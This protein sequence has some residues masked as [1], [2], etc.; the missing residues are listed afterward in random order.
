MTV[1]T[2]WSQ[3]LAFWQGSQEQEQKELKSGL[4]HWF[5]LPLGINLLIDGLLVLGYSRHITPPAA[6]GGE[7]PLHPFTLKHFWD[8]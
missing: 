7:L 4:Y 5:E 2:L 1:P 3:L 6:R 8:R